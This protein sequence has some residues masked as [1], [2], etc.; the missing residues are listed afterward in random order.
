MADRLNEIEVV[1]V[2]RV[3]AVE[4]L[5]LNRNDHDYMDFLN[6]RYDNLPSLKT[7]TRVIDAL[8]ERELLDTGQCRSRMAA[9]LV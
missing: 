6:G 7:W 4:D 5:S 2:S 1:K 3:M 8:N 9:L